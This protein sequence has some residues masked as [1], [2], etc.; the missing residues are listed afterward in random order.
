MRLGNAR[1]AKDI[2][3]GLKLS[4]ETEIEDPVQY[5]GEGGPTRLGPRVGMKCLEG[6]EFEIRNELH[7]S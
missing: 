2:G 1:C 7:L 4:V 3:G 6:T 5:G